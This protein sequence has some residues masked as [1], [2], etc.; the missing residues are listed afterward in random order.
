MGILFLYNTDMLCDYHVHTEFSDDSIYDMEDAVKD[1]IRIGLDEICFTDH[2]DFGVKLDVGEPGTTFRLGHDGKPLRNVDY[3]RYFAKIEM[4]QQKYA[5]QITIRKGLEF[6][7]Q[8]CQLERYQK[9][10]D[11]YPLDFV[12]HSNHQ[13]ND[14]EI[15]LPEFYAGKTQREYNRVYYEE[16]LR[17][18][19]A[20]KDY[21]VL[22]HL[23]AFN[24]YD[25]KGECPLSDFEDL[26]YEIFK[27]VSRDDKGIE[28]NTSNVRYGVRDLT[29]SRAILKIYHDLGGRIIT[30]GSD[31]HCAKDLGFNIENGKE[32]LKKI[33]FKEFCT[34]ENMTPIF[35]PL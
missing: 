3:P 20:Y 6:G 26:V 32:E 9:L 34:F 11:S 4:L 5:G 22:G 33:G 25:P 12:I 15:H 29:P 24:R 28:L 35:H 27:V 13:V 1:G 8:M 21:S 16:I 19:N 31:A 10:Y 17:T 2:V 23:D 7:L 18:V 30:I 14:I